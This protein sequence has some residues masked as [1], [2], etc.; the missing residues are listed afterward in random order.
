LNASFKPSLYA[1]LVH[2]PV[3]NKSGEVIAASVTN[4]DLHDLARLARTFGL[5][6]LF[7]VTPL[8]DQKE[9]AGRLLSHWTSGAGSRYNPA[10]REA[11]E[12]VRLTGSLAEALLKIEAEA[13]RRPMTVATCAR[14]NRRSID[15]D[16]CRRLLAEGDPLVLLFGTAWGLS[17][18][19]LEGADYRLEPVRGN[20]SYNHLSVRCAAAIIMDRL[21]GRPQGPTPRIAP[22]TEDT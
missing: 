22:H 18:E 6:G 3:R 21:V 19:L 2:H 1:A 11:L 14:E 8:E 17:E 15:F 10:R 16:R 20:G 13:G 12:T 7:V 5:K 4:L 9:L